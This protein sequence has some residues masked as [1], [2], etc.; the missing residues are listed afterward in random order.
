MAK[1]NIAPVTLLN[2]SVSSQTDSTPLDMRF[3]DAAGFVISWGSI[4]ANFA[5]IGSMDGVVYYDLQVDI[6]A[7]T[8]SS[9]S[10]AV[11][12]P[13]VAFPYIKVRVIPS[14]GTANVTVV[15]TA[16]GA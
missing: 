7:A 5:I 3:M 13:G 16:K 12:V 15:G 6:A 9:G 10:T 2:Q 4:T 8:G 1:K 11:N 14:V